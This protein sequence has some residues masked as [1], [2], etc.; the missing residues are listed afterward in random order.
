MK[1]NRSLLSLPHNAGLNPSL[2]GRFVLTMV[3]IP[4]FL[5]TAPLLTA[6]TA[7]WKENFTLAGL[8]NSLPNY[9]PVVHAIAETADAFYYGGTF[10]AVGTTSANNIVRV[11]K[12]TG[13]ASPLGSPTQNGVGAASQAVYAIAVIGTDLYVGGDFSTARSATQSSI[14]TNTIA[15]WDTVNNTWA[16]LGSAGQNGTPSTV[17]ALAVMG[18]KLYAGGDFSTVSSSTQSNISARRVALWDPATS[19]WAPLGSASQNGASNRIGALAVIG[20]DLY[21]GGSLTTVSDSS[22]AN[23]SANYV[24][25]WDSSANTWSPLGSATQNGT[26]GQETFCLAV[27]NGELYVGGWFSNV[28]SSSQ[29]N[30]SANQVAKW[31]PTAATWSRLGSS[32]QNGAPSFVRAMAVS[33]TDLYAGGNFTT[34][35]SATQSNLAAK[36][37]AKWSSTANTWSALGSGTANGVNNFVFSMAASGTDVH[38]GGTFTAAGGDFATNLAKWSTTNSTWTQQFATAGDG[39]GGGLVAANITVLLDAG[40]IVYAGG[41]FTTAGGVAVNNIAAWNKTTRTWSAL[42]SPAQNGTRLDSATYVRALALIGTDLYVTGNFTTVSSSSQDAI[43]A[44]NIAKWNTVTRT[45]S[46]LGT[47]SLNGLNNAGQSLLVVGTDLY[48]G[49]S[50]STVSNL[51]QSGL[52]ANRIAKWSTTGSAWSPLGSATQNGADAVVNCIALYGTDLYVAGNFST[53]KS[54]T[55]SSLSVRSIAKWD[56]VGATWSPLG[57]TAQNGLNNRPEAFALVG[58]DL[59]MAGH[60]QTASSSSQLNVTVNRVAKWNITSS[61]WVPLGSATQNGTNGITNSLALSGGD[62]IFGG[63]FGTVSSAT[64]NNLSA[65]RIAKWSTSANTWSVLGSSS[66]NGAD[67]EVLAIAVSGNDIYTGGKFLTVSSS[68]QNA[69]RSSRFALYAPIPDLAVEQ[70]AGTNLTDASGSV[71]FG[72]VAIGSPVSKTFTIRNTSATNLTDLAVSKDGAN[73]GDFS[74]DTTG[75]TTT[76]TPGNTTTF[77]VTFTPNSITSY[78]AALHIAS[79]VP[80]AKNP[81]D[82]AL[83]GTGIPIPQTIDFTNPGTQTVGG[84]EVALSATGGGSGNPVTFSIFSGPATVSGSILTTTGVGDVIVRASQAGNSTYAAAPDVDQTFTVQPVPTLSFASATP[85]ANPV[86]SSALPNLFPVVITRGGGSFGAVSAVVVPSLAATTPKG[87]A[88]YVYGTDYEFVAGTQAGA[89]V[90]FASGQTSA[91]VDVQLKTPAVTKPGQF[92]LTLANPSGG[93]TL[94]TPTSATVTI[95]AKDTVK[96]ILVLTSPATV[97]VPASFDVTGTVKDS[98]LSAFSV[99][100]NGTALTLTVNPLTSFVANT[101]VPFTATG[102][103]PENGLNT[104]LI[105]ATDASGNK[106]T[107]TKKL[108]YTNSRPNLAGSYDA[109]LVPV[110]TPNVDTT[111]IVTV[112]VAN[113][114]SFTGRATLSGV[115]VAFTGLLNNAGDAKFNPGLGEAFSLVDQ[116]EYSYLGALTLNV[117]SATGLTGTLWT[118]KTGGSSLA[119]F[120]GK[121][122]PYSKTVTA[123]A[124]ATGTFNLAF[125]CKDQSPAVN[126]DTYPQGDGFARMAVASTGSVS[127]SGRLADGSIYTGSGRLREDGTVA[128]FTQ[129]YRKLGALS[130]ELA[131]DE[132][133]VTDVTVSG[134]DLIWLRPALSRSLYYP[135]GWPTGVRVDTIGAKIVSPGPIDFGQGAADL[136]N[137]NA[138]LIFTEGALTGDIAKPVSVN[139][140][141]TTAGQVKLIPVANTTYKFVFPVIGGVATGLFS[142]S[143]THTDGSTTA[144]SGI[145]IG[146]GSNQGGYGYF[147]STPPEDTYGASGQSGR[148]YLDPA[149]P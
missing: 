112:T 91:T 73:S 7:A 9:A 93:A 111:G 103:A 87:F 127:L 107:F 92:K 41:H 6:Q 66:Q 82:I 45:W 132:V 61:T 106:L 100:L 13:V 149:T 39:V 109:L 98:G 49:G 144:Y 40:D 118:R 128:L 32:S 131:L 29:A 126:L 110:G 139:P 88:K 120:S 133:S 4:W 43:S 5:G 60:F 11:D 101:A 146:K 36:Y 67:N 48:V 134:S 124:S 28:K 130:G 62:L 145:V 1:P 23:I 72:S 26:D 113:S 17:R 22:Q 12:T 83:T 121:R 99:K 141:P 33:G 84:P 94:T 138:S 102:A 90:S 77:S 35:N 58:D 25:K 135:Q 47:A 34:V 140:G 137:G 108:S 27:M 59:Y 142:G 123:P 148:V 68:S 116:V 56:T 97:T 119:S 78:T 95:N 31:N 122:A 80:G 44:N 52:S 2:A 125:P 114:G 51:N 37:V 42:G 129:L 65:S 57:S 136:V 143:F 115:S 86:N 63:S 50:F 10:S 147:L 46:P 71:A 70:P 30:F 69:I 18:S 96:P 54:N 75:M 38:V 21:V 117:N 3:L 74:V 79:N 24:A 20:S 89:T 85:S 53:V 105:E 64:Q 14:T 19:T 16:P 104:L 76:V 15:K 81:F 55:Q 8:S